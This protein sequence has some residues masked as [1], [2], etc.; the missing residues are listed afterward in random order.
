VNNSPPLAPPRRTEFAVQSTSPQEWRSALR[1]MWI[2]TWRPLLAFSRWPKLVITLLAL[3][4]LLYSTLQPGS[5]QQLFCMFVC[6][7]LQ[8]IL[9]FYCLAVFGDMI[10]EELQ[11]NTLV[12]LTTRPMTRVR[13]Y[14]LKFFW[15][16]V[17]TEMLMLIHLGIL[18][19]VAW[20]RGVE[21]AMSLLALTTV[22]QFL[23][24][25]VFGALSAFLGVL[26]RRYM[27]LGLLYGMVVE[28]GIGQIPT[29]INALSMLR[30]IKSIMGHNPTVQLFSEWEPQGIIRAV[31][32]MMIATV[33]FLAAG[34]ITF[35]CKEF[36][37]NEG[38]QK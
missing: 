20:A 15:I 18:A 22:S 37:K 4:L 1:G 38:F 26:Q 14:L 19:I 7:F 24:I 36:H 12:F 13:L 2:L 34:A 25:M 17:W 31:A 10:R 21:G 33:V 6:L 11:A 29:N 27:V 16:W 3:P 30:H 5:R 32:A 23:A 28:I 9:P 35:S 8:L